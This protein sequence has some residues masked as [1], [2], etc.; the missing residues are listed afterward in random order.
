[1]SCR[2]RTRLWGLDDDKPFWCPN[3]MV[4][5]AV[6]NA[7]N[8]NGD[9]GWAH[10][11]VQCQVVWHCFKASPDSLKKIH[12]HQLFHPSS[13]SVSSNF[14]S[15]SRL[16]F[17]WKSV[18]QQACSRW[19]IHCHVLVSQILDSIFFSLVTSEKWR[20]QTFPGHCLL[21]YSSQ[22]YS[23]FKTQIWTQIILVF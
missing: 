15:R 14:D 4:L 20:G 17:G 2:E 6:C 3:G 13:F 10:Q 22:L 19:Y 12:C 8:I 5:N 23:L 18:H 11:Y 21:L 16:A 7:W 1:M 9:Q